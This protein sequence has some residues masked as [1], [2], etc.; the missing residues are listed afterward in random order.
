MGDFSMSLVPFA[1][2]VFNLTLLLLAAQRFS[3]AAGAFGFTVLSII[4]MGLAVVLTRILSRLFPIEQDPAI[5]SRI[6]FGLLILGWGPFMAVH[7]ANI[8]QLDS[9]WIYASSGSIWNRVFGATELSVLTLLQYL[10]ILFSALVAGIAFWRIH[11]RCIE[12][13]EPR[14]LWVWK[15]L[16]GIGVLYVLAALILT[17]PRGVLI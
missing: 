15:L 4:A 6:V 5:V 16:S 11:S 13:E 7:L 12:P 1:L 3:W 2:V 14:S 10:V 9:V 8:P 17:L